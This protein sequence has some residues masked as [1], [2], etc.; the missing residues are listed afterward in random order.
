M[1]PER[2]CFLDDE[3]GG[4]AGFA[5][6]VPEAKIG[7]AIIEGVVHPDRRGRGIGLRLLERAV[8]HSRHLGLELAHVSATPDLGRLDP[9][10]RKRRFAEVKRQ[11]QMRLELRDVTEGKMPSDYEIKRLE[12]G[13]E[14]LLA[15]LQNSAFIGSW[16]FAPNVPEELAYRLRMKG[17][18]V[19]DALVLWA[20]GKPSPT[21][22][23]AC[24]WQA[25]AASGS[26]G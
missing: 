2:D 19:S 6:A 26:S 25:G 15:D 7:R 20:D 5:L 24:N 11:W 21:A 4:A 14:P 18:H 23:R 8:E 12:E 22:G 10:L 1:T 9:P 16:G 17:S 13:E 3:N